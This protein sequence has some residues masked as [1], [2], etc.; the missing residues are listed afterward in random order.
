[1]WEGLAHGGVATPGLVVLGG[2]RK[3]A[4]HEPSEQASKQ[5][6]YTVSA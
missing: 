6:F 5:G 4:E 1:M 2:L 3:M